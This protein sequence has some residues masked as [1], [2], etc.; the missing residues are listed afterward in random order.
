MEFAGRSGIMVGAGGAGGVGRAGRAG[1][2]GRAGGGKFG[3]E[4]NVKAESFFPH[5]IARATIQPIMVQ[6]K[7]IL[8]TIVLPLFRIDLAIAMIVG[9]K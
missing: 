4:I 5:A 2:V 7:N 6:P 8:T 3:F 1:G 9:T